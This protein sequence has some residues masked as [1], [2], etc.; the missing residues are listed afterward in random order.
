MAQSDKHK[1]T[2]DGVEYEV[3]MLPARRGQRLFHRLLSIIG[4]PLAAAIGSLD[5]DAAELAPALSMLFAKATPDELDDIFQELA[6]VTLVDGKPLKPIYDVHFAGRHLAAHRWALFALRCQYADFFDAIA[7]A[8]ESGRLE[9]VMAMVEA[10][11]SP[12]GSTGASG[13]SS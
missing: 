9:E 5:D 2:I 12:M 3:S 8:L 11:R 13:A 4:P 10:F 1:A 7:S 6:E